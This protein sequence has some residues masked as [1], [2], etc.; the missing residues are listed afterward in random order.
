MVQNN[1]S[2]QPEIDALE[3]SDTAATAAGVTASIKD[4]E[5]IPIRAEGFASGSKSTF[6][7][8]VRLD[9]GRYLKLLVAGDQFSP[10]RL[11][12]YL[13][14]G[15]K[16]FYI[17]KE[18]Q[19]QYLQFCKTLSTAVLRAPKLS[20][21]VK[22]GQTLNH[23]E[24]MM[25]ILKTQG[26]SSENILFAKQFISDIKDLVSQMKPGRESLIP[27]FMSDVAAYEH[28]VGTSML[29]GILSYV[30]EIRMEKPVQIVGIAGL[31]HD[32]GLLSLP[33]NA[34]V[35]TEALP[36]E[37]KELYE[38]HPMKGA[39]ALRDTVDPA[40]LQAV[41][42]HHMRH[43]G[44]GFPERNNHTHT[45]GKVAEIIGICDELNHYIQKLK[46][47]PSINILA[48]MEAS[49]FPGFSRQIIYAFRSAFF[50]KTS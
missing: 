29:A 49:V 31:F 7:V 13:K 6:D 16:H 27:T 44:F 10:D 11:D 30:V 50:R 2:N 37:L 34:R 39:D 25:S 4:A 8:F 26:V 38:T 19:A 21:S 9:S 46:A 15:V 28:G 43:L 32:I 42:Q 24:E 1:Q 33:P 35:E 18:M 22:I 12:N 17:R 20:T 41:E 48:E 5:F 23:G 36:P 14:K 40:V 47:D 45:L 3:Q